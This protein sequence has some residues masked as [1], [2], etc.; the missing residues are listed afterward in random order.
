MFD[1]YHDG[2]VT[3]WDNDQ[4]R[5]VKKPAERT[6]PADAYEP[7][8]WLKGYDDGL[9]TARAWRRGAK[10]GLSGEAKVVNPYA[11][12]TAAQGLHYGSFWNYGWHSGRQLYLARQ[13]AQVVESVKDE[14]KDKVLVINYYPDDDFATGHHSKGHTEYKRLKRGMAIHAV[15][16]HLMDRY[17][18]D[19][20]LPQ[21]AGDIMAYII[22]DAEGDG[23]WCNAGIETVAAI[24]ERK[25]KREFK[26]MEEAAGRFSAQ[27]GYALG[28]MKFL[29]AL[30]QAVKD[31]NYQ[32]ERWNSHEC[33]MEEYAAHRFAG[34]GSESYYSDRDFVNGRYDEQRVTLKEVWAYIERKFPLIMLKYREM[35]ARK[36]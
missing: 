31:V 26:R 12:L 36:K 19:D 3:T 2:Y 33:R 20:P 6:P 11:H 21:T 22:A 7:E 16:T 29:K 25:A 30:E 13:V 27:C 15:V 14:L 10:A 34:G 1:C 9:R 18:K 8:K 4:M 17:G 35:K 24:K 23:S 28:T 5:P 32:Q